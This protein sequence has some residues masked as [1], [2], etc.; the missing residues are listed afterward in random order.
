MILQILF[1]YSFEINEV[2]LFPVRAASC[3]LIIIFSFEVI[4]LT[5]PGK[6]SLE[7]GI[8]TFVSIFWSKLSNQEPKDHQI[9]LF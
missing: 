7:R 4:L 8:T 6:L 3:P 9:E 1:M 5:N 2:N